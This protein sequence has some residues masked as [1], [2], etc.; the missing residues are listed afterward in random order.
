MGGRAHPRWD[1]AIK[2]EL[3]MAL[4]LSPSVLVLDDSED[5]L[6]LLKL[7]IMRLC[8]F[9][10]VT[11]RSLNEIEALGQ[12]ALNCRMAILDINLGPDEPNGVDVYRWLRSH[13]FSRPIVFLTGH[14]RTFP[15]VVEA[16]KL[17]DVQVLRK[18]LA[19][20]DLVTIVHGV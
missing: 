16:E 11:V 7:S 3:I 2:Q 12:R 1:A 17:G 13:G 10:A 5:L 4:G 15:L 19:T 14:A 8:G 18:P 9:H 6:E 20:A